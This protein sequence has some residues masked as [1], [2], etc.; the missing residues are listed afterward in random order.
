MR[1]TSGLKLR[2]SFPVKVCCNDGCVPAVQYVALDNKPSLLKLIVIPTCTDGKGKDF[3][4]A[5]QEG[6]QTYFLT[7][8][9]T[10]LLEKL[11]GLQLIKKFPAF[12]GTRRFITAFKSARHLSLS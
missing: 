5:R 4:R 2:V 9:S 10:V 12:Y 8:C 6:E 3:S 11:T 1:E 7:P